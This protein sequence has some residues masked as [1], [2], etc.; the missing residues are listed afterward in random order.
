MKVLFLI[1]HAKSNWKD[2]SLADHD[3]PLN[4][5]GRRDA[6]RMGWLLEDEG[7]MPDVIISSTSKRTRETV[8]LLLGELP[9]SGEVILRRGIYHGGLEEFSEVL[10][11]LDDKVISAMIVGHNPGIEMAVEDLTG[12]YFRMPTAALAVIRLPI[13]SWQDMTIEAEGE[14]LN[15]WIPKDL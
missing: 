7:L 5:R 10:Q 4:S 8:D 1:R 11:E 3:R 13:L 6:P 2:A 12:N 15:Y 9:F 14:L